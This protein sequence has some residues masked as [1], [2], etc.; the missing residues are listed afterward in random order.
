MPSDE[1]KVLVVDD[2]KDYL[3]DFSSLFSRK[4]NLITATGG[5]EALSVLSR[6]PVGVI[7]S[8][9]RMPKMTGSEL[10]AE[11]SKRHPN[12][13]RILLTG[14]SDLDAVVAAVNKGEIYRYV[15]KDLP[16]QEIEIVIRQ[17]IDKF[18]LEEANRKLLTAKKKLLKTLAMQENLTLFG[19]FG[20][21]VHQKIE[22][23]VM[24]LFNYVFQM[25]KKTSEQ[26][27]LGEFHKIQ[28]ALTRLRELSAFSEKMRMSGVS[29]QKDGL[30]VMIQEMVG[31]AN[32]AAQKDGVGVI[33]T[34]LDANLPSFPVHRY[35]FQRVLKELLENA[36]LFGTK[37][38]KEVV[39][40]SRYLAP[41]AE[42][43]D[44]TV[45]IEVADN[46]PG[47]DP[48]ENGKIFAPFFSTLEMRESPEGG[49]A[50]SPEEFNLTPYYHF[51]FGLSIAQWIVCL[52]HNGTIELNSQPGQGTVAAVNIPVG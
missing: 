29:I 6:E 50:P 9:Q 12:T 39:V 24:S 45:R 28:G 15:S 17:A 16:L 11:V 44:A 7:V 46:G 31:K 5:E 37:Q 40:R 22:G 20:Q 14:Y 26:A 27:A 3:G 21:Q 13:V 32:H 1:V 33:R 47:L 52:R 43:D 49:V 4:F 38:G 51:G 48:K 23:L 25:G 19:T 35:S 10:L 42:G 41:E 36:L 34:E 18:K 30:N 8:D 2:E